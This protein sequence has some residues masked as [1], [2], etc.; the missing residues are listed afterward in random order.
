MTELDVLVIESHAGAG[1]PG[2]AELA[3][4]GHRVHHC[5]EPGAHRFPCV[6]ITGPEACPIEAGIDVALVVRRRVT[7]SPTSLE[8]GVSCALRAG[9]PVVEDGPTVLDPYEGFVAG[10][11]D[12]DI[13]HAV[14]RVVAEGA[15][16]L[17]RDLVDRASHV[18]VAAD[19]DP[20]GLTCTFV[21]TGDRLRVVFGGTDVP[22]RVAH[23]VAVRALDA[24]RA[25]GRRF[26]QI[27]LGWGASTGD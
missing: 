19:L 6:G 27:D 14:E 9:I 2:A 5:Y 24:I 4:V 7:A 15:D 23:A 3:S 17:E 22:Q 1:R 25:D 10:R 18:L 20:T 8:Q 16:R 12:S 21:R 13:V 26:G 11:V